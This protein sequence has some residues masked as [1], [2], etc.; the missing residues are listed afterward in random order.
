MIL[1]SNKSRGTKGA[2]KYNSTLFLF[3]ECIVS[4]L[5]AIAKY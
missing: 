5:T 2:E 1:C 3:R 4:F